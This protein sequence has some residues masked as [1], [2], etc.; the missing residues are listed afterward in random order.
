[1]NRTSEQNATVEHALDMD[2]EMIRETAK[3]WLC[4][5]WSRYVALEQMADGCVHI[6]IYNVHGRCEIS[7]ISTYRIVAFRNHLP[8]EYAA[9]VYA[10]R[11]LDDSA[12]ERVKMGF[13][14]YLKPQPE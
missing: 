7:D 5:G 10:A 1:M 3:R 13:K 4:S 6:G 12:N 2:L 9:D 14:V 8:R 11:Y